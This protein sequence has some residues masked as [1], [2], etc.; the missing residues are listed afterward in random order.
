MSKEQ[1][2]DN[3]KKEKE[4][5]VRAAVATLNKCLAMDSENWAANKW[6]GMAMGALGEFVPLKEKIGNSFK[7]KEYFQKAIA[8]NPNDATSFHCMGAWCWNILQVSGV[9]RSVASWIF[10][11]PP[12]TSFEE[13]EDNLLR[14]HKLDTTQIHNS[15]MLGDLYNYQKSKT[16]AVK[17]Y[18]HAARECPVN[19]AYQRD[20]VVQA[21]KKLVALMGEKWEEEYKK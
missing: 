14:S 8:G 16:D 6:M 1:T 19:T 21:E 18:Y 12:S 9:E 13:C 4:A 17:W 7:I 3:Q 15:L 10:A 11:T 20:Y 5:F 2:G